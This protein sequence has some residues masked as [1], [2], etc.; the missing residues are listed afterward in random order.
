[1]PVGTNATV[2][3]MS[4]GDLE[5]LGVRLILGNAYHLYLRPGHALI[6]LAGGLHQFMGWERAI[7]TD[8]GGYQV[9]S[10]ADR[11]KLTDEGVT[12]QSHLDGSHHLFTPE[13]V[14][15]IQV[16]LAL[17]PTKPCI[18][19]RISSA[20][21]LVKDMASILAGSTPL[22]PTSRATRWVRTRV[23]PLPAP[24]RMSRGPSR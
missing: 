5:D 4:V 23:F 21:L 14:M 7:L 16:A 22:A 8:S 20:A 19:P 11:R 12:F 2:K 9:L 17:G 6:R 1:M 10:L 3:A 24:A 13:K 18:L 15:E